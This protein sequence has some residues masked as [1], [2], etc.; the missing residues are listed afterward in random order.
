MTD[1][2]RDNLLIRIDERVKT[3]QDWTAKHDE[4]HKSQRASTQRWLLTCFSLIG[5][6]IARL[7]F[8]K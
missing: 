8:W 6:V 1:D 3:L 5:G 4:S 2:Q 7:V